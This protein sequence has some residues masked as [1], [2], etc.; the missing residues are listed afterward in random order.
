M[1]RGL[2]LGREMTDIPGYREEEAELNVLTRSMTE[3]Y[4]ETGVL[5]E[6][7]FKAVVQAF[8]AQYERRHKKEK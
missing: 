8:V 5:H 4:D 3:F 2:R 6:D 7:V 1:G